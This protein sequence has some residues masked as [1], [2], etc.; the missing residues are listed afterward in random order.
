MYF[1]DFEILSYKTFFQAQENI[2]P[3]MFYTNALATA[4]LNNSNYFWTVE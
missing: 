4:D 3:M 1:G 2:K